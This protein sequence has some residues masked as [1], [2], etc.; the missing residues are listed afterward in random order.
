[1]PQPEPGRF[2]Y[3]FDVGRDSTNLGCHPP[4]L[5]PSLLSILALRALAQ[6]D[7]DE[8]DAYLALL[9]EICDEAVSNKSIMLTFNDI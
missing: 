5:G 2:Q 8:R 3:G 9:D 4:T 1:M 7:K 6:T